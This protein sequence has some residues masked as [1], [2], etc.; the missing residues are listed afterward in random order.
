LTLTS[1]NLENHPSPDPA[2]DNSAE[3]P[4]WLQ[5]L[6]V[7]V[8]VLFCIELGLVL[9]GLPWTRFWFNNGLLA[10]WPALQHLMQQGFV[11]GAVTGLGVLDIWLGIVEAVRYR[12]RR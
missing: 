11:R 6:F 10:Q 1:T 9:I 7:V 12:D 8:Y 2:T 4:V 5:R 3:M